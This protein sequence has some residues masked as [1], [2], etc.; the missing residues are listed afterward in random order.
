MSHD[1]L[2]AVSKGMVVVMGVVELEAGGATVG[3]A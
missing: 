2:G 1:Q 3:V